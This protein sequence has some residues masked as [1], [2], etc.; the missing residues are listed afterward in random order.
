MIAG[1]LSIIVLLLCMVGPMLLYA[2]LTGSWDDP[3]PDWMG[4]LLVV[5]GGLGSGLAVL[6]HKFVISKI[7]GYPDDEALRDWYSR[8]K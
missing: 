6:I 4:W 1:L 8:Y 2:T 3:A 7:G 5:G